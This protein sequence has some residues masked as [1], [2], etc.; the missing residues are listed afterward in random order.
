MSSVRTLGWP[1]EFP[2]SSVVLRAHNLLNNARHFPIDTSS[3]LPQRDAL[4]RR[5]YDVEEAVVNLNP[6]G[7]SQLLRNLVLHWKIYK[8]KQAYDAYNLAKIRGSFDG[9]IPVD[10]LRYRPGVA[11]E[12]IV[13][14]PC[15][16]G[17]KENCSGHRKSVVL[18]IREPRNPYFPCREGC[19]MPEDWMYR[20]L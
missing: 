13:E 14:D 17:T 5:L 8:L 4:S 15:T 12:K 10:Q 11:T 19:L 16:C 18:E 9:S 2:G 6:S 3:T 1:E 20:K 7:W